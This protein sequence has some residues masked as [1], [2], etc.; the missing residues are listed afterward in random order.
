MDRLARRFDDVL[1]SAGQGG[2]RRFPG[3]TVIPDAEPGQGPLMGIATALPRI[4][5]DLAFVIACDIPRIDLDFVERLIERAAGCD[6]ALPDRGGGRYEPDWF[7]D[8]CDE[9]GLMIWQDAMFS[10]NLYPADG[11][12]WSSSAG[13][14]WSSSPSRR[15]SGSGTS[16]PT[17]TTGNSCAILLPFDFGRPPG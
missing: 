9:L 14:V 12:S 8:I 1:I 3:R 6:L 16:T 10:C 7:Y 2:G 17:R 15:E 11:A 13:C 4:R 5:H